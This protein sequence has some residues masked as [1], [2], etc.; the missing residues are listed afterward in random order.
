MVSIIV[1]SILIF[2]A[3]A[4]AVLLW[5]LPSGNKQQNLP[6]CLLLL[7]TALQVLIDITIDRPFFSSLQ[8]HMFGTTF[9]FLCAPLL[10]FHL[11]GLFKISVNRKW[12]HYVPFAVLTAYY[13]LEG[14]SHTIFFTVFGIQYIFYSTVITREL[15]G[16]KKKIKKTWMFFI[17]YSYGLCWLFAIGANIFSQFELESMAQIMELIAFMTTTVLFCGFIFFAMSRPEIFMYVKVSVSNQIRNI[18]VSQNG[19]V[20]RM[21][22]IK[23]LF[24]ENELYADP[25][26]NR[27]TLAAELGIDIQQL[28]KEINQYFKMNFS[29]LIN[30]HRIQAAKVLLE[31]PE[32]NIKDIY[33]GV[34][35]SSRS[36]FN[37]SFK[38]L[39]GKTPSDYRKTV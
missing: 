33:Y 19:V 27:K 24:D 26:L 8:I 13:F 39:T 23:R 3:I 1:Q 20:K 2:I 38:K 10:Y 7:I 22:E 29:E 9:I 15:L 37:T 32:L 25:L 36:A 35:F 5:V 12:P 18:D 30:K 6:L 11:C 16:R 21:E 31:K 34:G 14:F 28:S 4:L 17:T